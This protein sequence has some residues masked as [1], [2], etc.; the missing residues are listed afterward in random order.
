MLQSTRYKWPA[1]E[2]GKFKEKFS[3]FLNGIQAE[4]FVFMN[5]SVISIDLKS[6]KSMFLPV[7]H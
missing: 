5:L 7:S 6:I 1:S 2:I 4:N 3:N